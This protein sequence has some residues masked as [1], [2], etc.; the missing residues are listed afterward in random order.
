MF[1]TFDGGHSL[2]ESL[3]TFNSILLNDPVLRGT[4]LITKYENENIKRRE[5]TLENFNLEYRDIPNM[6]LS[7]DTAKAAQN[8]ID[9]AFKETTKLF[10]EVHSQ[11]IIDE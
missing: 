6:F 11:R 2:P 3:G 9:A 7:N 5:K 8:A 1:L 4:S 10:S